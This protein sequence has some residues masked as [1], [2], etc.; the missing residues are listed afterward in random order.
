MPPK[1]KQKYFKK[2]KNNNTMSN[3]DVNMRYQNNLERREMVA[4]YG[5]FPSILVNSLVKFMIYLE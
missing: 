2:I 3:D 4:G 1:P 5:Y